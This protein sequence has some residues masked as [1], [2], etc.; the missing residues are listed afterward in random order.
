MKKCATVFLAGLLFAGMARAEGT[1][2]PVK[3]ETAGDDN[4]G[5]VILEAMTVMRKQGLKF[6]AKQAQRAAIEAVLKTADV[7]GCVLLEQELAALKQE[8]KGI[9]FDSGVKIAYGTNG[10][11]VATIASNTPAANTMLK[12]GDALLAIDGVAISSQKLTSVFAPLRS[13]TAAAAR[14]KI[15]CAADGDRKSVV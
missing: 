9:F 13:A 3:A 12:P 7:R 14:L 15:K 6:E 11:R 1:N 2:S 8:Q 5:P 4:V 10:W